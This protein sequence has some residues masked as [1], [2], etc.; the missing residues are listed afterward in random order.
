MVRWALL[1]LRSETDAETDDGAN[2]EAKSVALQ[3]SSVGAA[4]AESLA[5][6]RLLEN[7]LEHLLCATGA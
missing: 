3:K 6:K 2:A 7:L 5:P 1:A 4:R